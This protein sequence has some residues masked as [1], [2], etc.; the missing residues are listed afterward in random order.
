MAKVNRVENKAVMSRWDLVKFQ[1]L[2]YCYLKKIS[3]S[4]SELECLTLL[5]LNQPVILTDF[6][7]DVSDEAPWIFKSSQSV[8]NAINKCYKKGLVKRD[9][10]DK[11]VMILNEDLKIITQAPI[12][13]ELKFLAKDVSEKE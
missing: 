5:S 6:C 4:E 7:F 2:T 12:L 10:N 9:P 3:V 1:I 8:R 13:Y 11:K